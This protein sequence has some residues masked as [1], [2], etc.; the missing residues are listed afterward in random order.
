MD[1]FNTFL[2]NALSVANKYLTSYSNLKCP[3]T[4]YGENSVELSRQK[5]RH[6]FKVHE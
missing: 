3:L 2:R 5:A 4:S 1:H 6:V